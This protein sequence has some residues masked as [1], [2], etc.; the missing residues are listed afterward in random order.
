MTR[1]IPPTEWKQFFEN[2][3]RDLREWLTSIEVVRGDNSSQFLMR[4]LPFAGASVQNGE[5]DAN[6]IELMFGAGGGAPQSHSIKNPQRVSFLQNKNLPGCLLA[7]KDGEGTKIMVHI[8]QPLPALI[9]L[10]ECRLVSN[11]Y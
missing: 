3:S 10:A 8:Q 4:E 5:N 11:V 1:E 7:I 9:G 6:K 2:L